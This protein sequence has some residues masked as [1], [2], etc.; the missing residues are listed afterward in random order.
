MHWTEPANATDSH[1]EL[2][3]KLWA[4]ANQLWANAALKLS[5]YSPTVLGLVFLRY[6]DAKFG[7][8][9]AE[10]KPQ[11]GARRKI[12]PSDYHAAGVIY[13][14]DEARF[15]RLL[16]LPEG[17]N[18]GQAINEA[19][20]SIEKENPRYPFGIPRTDN[21]NYLWIQHFQ[22]ALNRADRAGWRRLMEAIDGGD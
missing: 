4:P 6:A 19:M 18:T 9:Q 21:G 8:V 2:E 5:E 22:S 11:A 14:P 12:G 3:K 13:L 1:S 17:S 10:L 15:A 20:R 16:S 7:A